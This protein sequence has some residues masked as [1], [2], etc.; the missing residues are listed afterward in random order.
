VP[1]GVEA[2]EFPHRSP[3]TAGS[4]PQIL[5]YGQLIPLHG[6][7]AVLDAAMSSRGEAFDWVIIGSGQDAPKVAARIGENP[8]PHIRWIPWVPYAELTE[9]IAKS[10]VCLGIFGGSRKAASVIPNKAYQALSSGRHLVTRASPAMAELAF[11]P[12]ITLVEA[13]SA[14]ALLDGID[15]AQ[16]EGC[17]APSRNLVD[18]FS[19]ER[20]GSILIG[21]I[22]RLRRKEV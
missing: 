5:F 3:S 12:G 10:D 22:S 8:P 21:Y 18:S 1:V 11:D 13:E 4:R 17:P 14:T 7:E 19:S 2:G 16:G 15:Q 9:W 6:I 20:I